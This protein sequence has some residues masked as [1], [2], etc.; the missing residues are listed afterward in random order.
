MVR[1]VV[2]DHPPG[3]RSTV[4]VNFGVAKIHELVGETQR[5]VFV[6]VVLNTGGVPNLPV[7]RQVESP[8]FVVDR[9]TVIGDS[10]RQQPRIVNAVLKTD[11]R[12]PGIVV[13]SVLGKLCNRIGTDGNIGFSEFA[14]V[15]PAE[16]WRS[17]ARR[18]LSWWYA[19]SMTACGRFIFRSTLLPVRPDRSSAAV[20]KGPSPSS[21]ATS[22]NSIS[23]SER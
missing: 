7:Q 19:L 23:T 18:S 6:Q 11:G 2:A 10:D 9:R 15:L 12:V 22:S 14:P 5:Y 13:V 21:L 20:S 3:E 8:V 16:G 17:N 4:L 1:I